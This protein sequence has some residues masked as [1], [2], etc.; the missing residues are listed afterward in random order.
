MFTSTYQ[1]VLV[2]Q[3]KNWDP[4]V[5]GP[6]LAIDKIPAVQYIQISKHSVNVEHAFTR[7]EENQVILA[8]IKSKATNLYNR[9]IKHKHQIVTL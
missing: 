5:L 6:A 7:A 3:M 8:C 1:S 9:S 4:L 2:V